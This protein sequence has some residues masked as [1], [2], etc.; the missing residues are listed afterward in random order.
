MDSLSPRQEV[1]REEMHI[2]EPPFGPR[3]RAQP[4][5]HTLLSSIIISRVILKP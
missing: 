4:R 5:M 3:M 1:R 2:S